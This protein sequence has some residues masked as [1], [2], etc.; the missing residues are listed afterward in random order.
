MELLPFFTML[1]TTEAHKLTYKGTHTHRGTQ[2]DIHMK[3][4]TDIQ[5]SGRHTG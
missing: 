4:P 3:T 2:A 5:K 1:H